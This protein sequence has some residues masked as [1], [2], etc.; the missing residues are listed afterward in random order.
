LLVSRK[1]VDGGLLE[2]K[3]LGPI[4][5]TAGAERIDVGGTRQQI[6]IATLQLAAN[7]VVPVDRLLE[8]IYGEDLPPTSRSQVQIS[9]SSL[10]RM[11]GRHNSTAIITKN[12]KK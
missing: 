9:I 3:I 5:V 12:K 8:A 7:H 6:V 10:R 11:L 2:F 1:I 4:E